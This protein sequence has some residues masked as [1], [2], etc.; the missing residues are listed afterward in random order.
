MEKNQFITNTEQC[1]TASNKE[2]KMDERIRAIRE[3]A[4]YDACKRAVRS[5]QEREGRRERQEKL[6]LF[7][8]KLNRQDN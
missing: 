8:K 1:I 2:H 6:S 5:N 3:K 7:Q 4:G